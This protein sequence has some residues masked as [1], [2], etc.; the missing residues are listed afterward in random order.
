MKRIFLFQWSP[1]AAAST[2]AAL[3]A[4]GFQVR[5]EAEDGARGYGEVQREPPDAVVL[6]LA[7]RPSHSRDTA[8]AL[9]DAKRTRPLPMLFMDGDAEA[10]EKVSSVVSNATFTT[11]AELVPT[12]QRMLAGK[13]EAAVTR[14]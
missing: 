1:E 3:E 11:A 7:R 13:P 4:S 9:H 12:L 14:S 8:R 6:D 2:A 5:Y 10:R